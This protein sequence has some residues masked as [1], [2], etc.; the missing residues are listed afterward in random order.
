MPQNRFC[1]YNLKFLFSETM[2]NSVLLL[3]S[4]QIGHII[5]FALLNIWRTHSTSEIISSNKRVNGNV[6][7]YLK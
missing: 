3:Q 5:S 1:M 6:A 2:S 4:F 7:F